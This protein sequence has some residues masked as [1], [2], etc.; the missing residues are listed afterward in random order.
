MIASRQS[1]NLL[2]IG[3]DYISNILAEVTGIKAFF[4]DDDTLRNKLFLL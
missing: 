3:K 1:Q 2:E 4:L